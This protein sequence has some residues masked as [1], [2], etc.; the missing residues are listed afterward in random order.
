MNR[1]GVVDNFTLGNQVN[2]VISYDQYG[3]VDGI[4]STKGG[5][6]L[7]NRSYDFNNITGNL[8]SRMGLNSSGGSVTE[9]FTYDDLNRLLT[10]TAG[11][12][13]LSVSYDGS[14]HGNITGKTDVGTY[15]YTGG[16]HNVTSVTEPTELMQNLPKQFIDYTKSGKVSCITDTLATDE[17][18]ELNFIYGPDENRVKTLFTVDDAV[19][20]TKYFALDQY[21]K[22]T[23]STGN[24]REL[25]YIS[26]ADGVVAV[27]EKKNYQD[28]IFYIHKDYLGSYEVIS[29]QNG[30]VKE[31]YNF[32]P[33]GRRRNPTDWSYNNVPEEFFLDR[34]FTGHEHLDKFELINMNGR[35][36]DQVMAMF[37]SPDDFVQSP[38]LTQN[39]NRYT[40]CLNNPLKFTDPSGNNYMQL[41]EMAY[42]GNFINYY[43][44]ESGGGGN[45]QQIPFPEDFA[46]IDGG[47]YA[48]WSPPGSMYQEWMTNPALQFEYPSYEDFNAA[49]GY[50]VYVKQSPTTTYEKFSIK[51]HES[52][53]EITLPIVEICYKKIWIS[54]A[55][56]SPSGQG[57]N[58][59]LLSDGA[60]FGTAVASS[61]TTMVQ[62]S[63]E[64]TQADAL[65]K[66][67]RV[68]RVIASEKAA[69]KTMGK[70]ATGAKFLGS[71][72]GVVSIAD[73][74][75]KAKNSFSNEGI[76]SIDGWLNVG[77]IGIDGALMLLKSNPIVLTISVGYGISDASG[78]LEYKP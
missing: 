28:S 73:H 19:V 70:V 37:L 16:V 71:A 52:Y 18:R 55:V 45:G 75:T 5:T 33:W 67:N 68:N 15:D 72:L 11:Q 25:Y 35:V 9:S 61:M 31:R 3:F 64:L 63:A 21:E 48:R 17:V 46:D 40:Y 44:P 49:Q 43:G 30:T 38:D 56:E 66:I 32:D 13:T 51:S 50:Y 8:T 20:R 10:C 57:A 27:L 7:Q 23:D 62:G 53:F 39:F 22:E 26:G 69:F 65:A 14:G 78:Y 6:Y 54:T 34:G 4:T 42:E 74:F 12:D 24:V 59:G 29:N 76:F 47:S 60:F 58:G 77:T 2:P 41:L 1:Y 36:Y